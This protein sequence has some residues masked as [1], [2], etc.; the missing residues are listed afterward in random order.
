ME[1]TKGGPVEYAQREARGELAA[2]VR[3]MWFI[4][5]PSPA[6]FERIFPMTDVHL[7]V[8]LAERPYRVLDAADAPWRVL[9]AGFSSGLRSRFVVSENPD[10]IAN[11]GAVV[12]A[13]G[14]RALGLDPERLAGRVSSQPWLDGVAALG[15]DVNADEV[16][17]ALE[18]L[19][20]GMLRPDRAPD[21]LVHD[22]IERLEA[23]P[24]QP[25]APLAT[26]HGIGHPGFV[27]R[28][29]R[30]TG[31]TPKR[32]AE[33]VRFHRLIDAMPVAGTAS[34]S[35]LAVEAGYYDQSHVIRDVKRFTGFTPADYHRR[36]SAAGPDA[37]RF[38]PDPDAAF[39]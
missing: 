16:L 21:P 31:I 39:L 4:R 32:Y 33:L 36:V 3:S 15:P 1:F 25:I 34:W 17:D 12:R 8:N 23:N 14:L 37:V 30:A 28:F 7:I 18:A 5:G 26:A 11:A 22:A 6:R 9:G 27:A 38:V 29:R 19:L 35:D 10:P 2:A 20:V 13:D 24:T